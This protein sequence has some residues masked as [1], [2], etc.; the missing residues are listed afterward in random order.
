M[1]AERDATAGRLVVSSAGRLELGPSPAGFS[2]H[3]ET[4]AITC[5]SGD[6]ETGEWRGIRVGELLERAGPAADATHL[7]VTGADDYRVCVPLAATL[8]ALLAVERLDAPDDGALPRFL[9]TGVG[10]TRSV[11]RVRRIET[12][13]LAPGEDATQY[14]DL[15]LEDE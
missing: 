8:D 10:G 9:G 14:E 3:T 7:V 13:S 4:H 1:A 5:S 12:A 15:Q 11:K 2:M 6:R